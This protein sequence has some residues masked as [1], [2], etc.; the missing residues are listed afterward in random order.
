MVTKAPQSPQR[1][2]P[3][4]CRVARQWLFDHPATNQ[5]TVAKILRHIEQS[6]ADSMCRYGSTQEG[7]VPSNIL[8]ARSPR[9]GTLVV[10]VLVW[11]QS[12]C[13]LLDDVLLLAQCA[14]QP[15]Q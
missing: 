12:F 7:A 6:N 15:V 11:A 1:I 8:R 4:S 10:S 9:H 13:R 2:F 5:K 3:R 14:L